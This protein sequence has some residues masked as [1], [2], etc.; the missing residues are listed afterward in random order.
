MQCTQPLVGM[1][2]Q[3]SFSRYRGIAGETIWQNRSPYNLTNSAESRT[4]SFYVRTSQLE[5]DGGSC[6]ADG[7]DPFDRY[8]SSAP[9]P[10]DGY[11]R[12]AF[13]GASPCWHWVTNEEKSVWYPSIRPFRQTKAGGWPVLIER[14]KAELI[15]EAVATHQP[16][17]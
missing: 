6:T 15:K 3:L 10:R 14:V 17:V 2:R 9:G 5:R 13:V 12:L 16:T 4:Y 11:T 7:F 8:A 1:R